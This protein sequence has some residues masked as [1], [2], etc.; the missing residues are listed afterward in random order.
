[1]ENYLRAL[2]ATGPEAIRIQKK[3]IRRWEDLPLSDAIQAGVDAFVG[4]WGTDE[5]RR[6]MQAFRDR[7]SRKPE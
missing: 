4:S 6:L 1:V 2:F 7:R 5:P 3:L